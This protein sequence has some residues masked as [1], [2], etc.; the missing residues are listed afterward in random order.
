MSKLV[1]IISLALL[2]SVAMSTNTAGSVSLTAS[3]FNATAVKVFDVTNTTDKL[4][5]LPAIIPTAG[6][7]FGPGADNTTVW[8]YGF[9]YTVGTSGSITGLVARKVSTAILTSGNDTSGTEMSVAP[10]SD[11]SSTTL[12]IATLRA[13]VLAVGNRYVAAAV[14]SAAGTSGATVQTLNLVVWA[15]GSTTGT[16]TAVITSAADVTTGG[17]TVTTTDYNIGNVWYQD[18]YFYLVYSVVAGTG[19]GGSI[20]AWT[21]N[22]IYLQA[23][24]ASNASKLYTSPM[25]VV[26]S[27]TNTVS[28]SPRTTGATSVYAVGGPSN[29]TLPSYV[30]VLYKSATKVIMGI[31]VNRTSGS[32]GTAN[33][34]T[35]DV[36]YGSGTTTGFTF[37]PSGVWYSTSYYGALISNSTEGSGAATFAYSLTSCN[38]STCADSGL[39]VFSSAATTT[40]QM[41]SSYAFP[42]NNTGYAIVASYPTTTTGITAFTAQMF[43]STG[44]ATSTSVTSIGTVQGNANFFRDSINSIWFG[45]ALSD[46]ANSPDVYSGYIARLIYTI[47]PATSSSF[48][49]VLASFFAFLTLLLASLFAF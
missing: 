33:T 28:A 8:A 5:W 43:N 31:P 32:P 17:G 26:S 4:T 49:N 44:S 1:A 16:T 47:F 7:I 18:G 36:T 19:S 35:T 29:Y 40:G 24:G 48:G 3:A 45:Y 20:T 12:S 10:S 14:V 21:E 9:T 34:L 37:L 27:L 15:A 42:Y 13:Q 39:G 25:A 38:S 6:V 2:V 41:V 11:T 22:A 23:V 30:Y 46:T